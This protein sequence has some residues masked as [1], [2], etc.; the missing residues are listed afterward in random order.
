MLTDVLSPFSRHMHM[1][2]KKKKKEKV[3]KLLKHTQRHVHRLKGI[4]DSQHFQFRFAGDVAELGIIRA[5]EFTKVKTVLN[6]RAHLVSNA[7]LTWILVLILS[8]T[9]LWH[10]NV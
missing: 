4:F 5:G 1:H 3:R 9:F 2:T 8:I 6:P 10:L 7:E